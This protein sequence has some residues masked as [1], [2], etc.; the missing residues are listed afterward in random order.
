MTIDGARIYNEGVRIGHDCEEKIRQIMATLKSVSP[1]SEMSVRL[2]KSGR[3]YEA[4]LW[5]K[6]DSLPIGVYNRG[7][8]VTHVLDTVYRKVKK[9]CQKAWKVK[10]GEIGHRDEKSSYGQEH[11][12]LAG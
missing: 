11:L 10:G 12:A 9:Q 6:A 8:S 1:G 2:L 5:G 4:L 3:S 7:P